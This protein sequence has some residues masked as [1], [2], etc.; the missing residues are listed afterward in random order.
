MKE[1]VTL[2]TGLD[3]GGWTISH[4][5]P[6]ERRGNTMYKSLRMYYIK[7]LEDR[8]RDRDEP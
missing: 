7:E 4:N 8:T 3:Q 1:G 6:G 5:A 2:D